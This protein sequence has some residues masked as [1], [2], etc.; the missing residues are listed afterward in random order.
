[1]RASRLNVL[2]EKDT[3]TIFRIS[4]PPPGI[5]P[6]GIKLRRYGGVPPFKL[7]VSDEHC[8]GLLEKVKLN[9]DTTTNDEITWKRIV[10]ARLEADTARI[11]VNCWVSCESGL[12]CSRAD[13]RS[14]QMKARHGAPRQI[15]R[16]DEMEGR[17]D[18]RQLG[19]A[20]AWLLAFG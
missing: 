15:G 19:W 8:V 17:R 5:G 18:R 10:V 11:R 1:M 9:A 13:E 20:L 3:S 16:R 6:A 7:T 4:G 12:V 14:V 2:S